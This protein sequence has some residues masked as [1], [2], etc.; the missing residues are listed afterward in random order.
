MLVLEVRQR[1]LFFG[2]TAVSCSCASTAAG[3]LMQENA[4]PVMPPVI[5]FFQSNQP[6]D[7]PYEIAGVPTT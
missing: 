2:S 4:D 5:R 7:D 3:S 6:A 1:I